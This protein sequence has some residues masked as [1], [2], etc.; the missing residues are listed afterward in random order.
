MNEPKIFRISRWGAKHPHLYFTMPLILWIALIMWGCLAPPSKLPSLASKL[1]DKFEHASCYF[2][3][4][5][6][7]LRGWL[8]ERPVSLLPCLVIWFL[9]STW[10]YYIEVL[11]RWTG[12]RSYDLRDEAAN[13]V[14]ALL[15]ILA[16]TAFSAWW[17]SAARGF[18]PALESPASQ[19]TPTE[20]EENLL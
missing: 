16:W 13:A 3:L 1:N 2:V 11:Q 6:L 14:G 5:V 12:Y 8:R 15:G 7:L 9:A 4:A 18:T 10:G 17:M 19:A 20:S